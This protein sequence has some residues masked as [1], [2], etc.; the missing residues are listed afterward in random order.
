[1]FGLSEDKIAKWG[2]NKK[3]AKLVKAAGTR[4]ENLRLAVAKAMGNVDDE[5]V[6]NILIT[7]LRDRNPEIRIAAMESLQKINNKNAIEHVRGLIND[8]DTK[9]SEK[10]REVLKALHD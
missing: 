3:A 8:S 10:A 1:M 4:K 6:F 5:Q 9:V 2:E 7:F